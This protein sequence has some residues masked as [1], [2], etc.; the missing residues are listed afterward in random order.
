MTSEM[1]SVRITIEVCA[2]VIPNKPEP[3]LTRQW[4]VYSNKWHGSNNK[5]RIKLMKTIEDA[6]NEYAATLRDP[7]RFN[8]VRVD[9]IYW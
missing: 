5:D 4:H 7:S 3:R 2:G 8:W 6:A 1:T 9:W